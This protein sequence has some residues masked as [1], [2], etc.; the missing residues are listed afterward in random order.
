MLYSVHVN[1][2]STEAVMNDCRLLPCNTML[3]KMQPQNSRR[4]YT[5][6]SSVDMTV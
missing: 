1:L 6:V 5:P 3:I 4:L 2:I